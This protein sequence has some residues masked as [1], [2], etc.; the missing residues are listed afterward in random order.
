MKKTL[1]FAFAVAMVSLF[2]GGFNPLGAMEVPQEESQERAV[3]DKDARAYFKF[4]SV[5]YESD[6]RVDSL[7]GYEELFALFLKF[8]ENEEELFKIVKK[9]QEEQSR[10]VLKR[11]E[12]EMERKEWAV[13][14]KKE[15]EEMIVQKLIEACEMAN[16]FGLELK[17]VEI[18]Q[19]EQML[20]KNPSL[21]AQDIANHLLSNRFEM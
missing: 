6:I 21:S 14:R 3:A 1:F 12:D 15:R 9:S 11:E 17:E 8:R 4:L 18:E 7:F 13:E 2:T 10:K 16:T 20:Q 5:L 19:A